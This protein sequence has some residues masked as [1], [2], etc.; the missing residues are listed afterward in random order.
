MS[1]YTDTSKKRQAD[2]D[3]LRALTGAPEGACFLPGEPVAYCCQGDAHSFALHLRYWQR[4]GRCVRKAVRAGLNPGTPKVLTFEL[5]GVRFCAR[6][7]DYM[8]WREDTQ[9]PAIDMAHRTRAAVFFYGQDVALPRAAVKGDNNEA[10]RRAY[11]RRKEEAMAR[12]M[13]TGYLP[14]PG[15]FD[16]SPAAYRIDKGTV[17]GVP[18]NHATVI[19]PTTAAVKNP[20][21]TE[22]R[23]THHPIHGSITQIGES[24][25]R[26]L[27]GVLHR[28]DDNLTEPRNLPDRAGW[29]QN[30]GT[31]VQIVTPT[32]THHVPYANNRFNYCGTVYL[33]EK[34]K[35]VAA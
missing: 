1:Y 5:Q 19:R 10:A 17:V 26:V 4:S 8:V 23:K 25:Y 21:V 27:F 7:V 12:C 22:V 29:V 6:S 35:V 3:T 32:G 13:P 14:L 24:K 16:G 18:F 9:P 28:T 33:V 2:N 31:H 30:A 34:E 11:A 20:A 15:G